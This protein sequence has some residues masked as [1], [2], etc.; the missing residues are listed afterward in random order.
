MCPEAK[1]SYIKWYTSLANVVEKQ[2][3]DRINLV[4]EMTSGFQNIMTQ[5]HLQNKILA[6]DAPQHKLIKDFREMVDRINAGEFDQM[7]VE[8][9][10]NSFNKEYSRR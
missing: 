9:F 6:Q 8:E 1:K 5:I 10:D 3:T 4:L 2:M 7:S